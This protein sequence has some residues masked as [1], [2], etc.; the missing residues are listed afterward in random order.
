MIIGTTLHGGGAIMDQFDF[1][2]PQERSICRMELRKFS[3]SSTT[4]KRSLRMLVEK[5][6]SPDVLI[7]RAS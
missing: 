2:S 1:F 7:M 4:R 3:K 5:L 6:C